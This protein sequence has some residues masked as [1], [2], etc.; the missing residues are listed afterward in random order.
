MS[1]RYQTHLPPGTYYA[2]RRTEQPH[3][4]FAE[5]HDYEEFEAFLAQTLDRTGTKLLAYCWMPAAIHLALTA[6][7]TPIS[8]VMRRVTRYCT[9]QIQKRTGEKAIYTDSFPVMLLE[10]ETDLPRL[11][12][13]IHWIPVVAGVAATPDEYPYSS[14]RAYAR[15]SQSLPVHTTALQS[16][17]HAPRVH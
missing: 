5:P 8:D 2:S 16:L 4:I 11:L 13:Y 17:I 12:R 9:Q 6:D 7:Q 15:T 1:W 3:L 14:H 10:L